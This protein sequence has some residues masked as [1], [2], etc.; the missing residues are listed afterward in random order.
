MQV[1]LITEIHKD[2]TQKYPKK[3]KKV[4]KYS[5]KEKCKLMW[6]LSWSYRK[7][8]KSHLFSVQMEVLVITWHKEEK[9][10]VATW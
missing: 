7:V 5:A 2:A 1:Y 3:T 9:L 4:H 6:Y 10:L 8:Y